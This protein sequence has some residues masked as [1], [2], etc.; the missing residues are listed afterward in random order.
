MYKHLLVGI[1]LLPLSNLKA[2]EVL[3]T[4]GGTY[5][6]STVEMSFT[7]GEMII[8]TENSSTVDLTQGFHQPELLVSGI[9]NPSK[10]LI[11]S[12]YP[13]PTADYINVSL[14]D[15][16][17]TYYN[18]RSIDGKLLIAGKMTASQTQIDLS[19][20]ERGVYTVEFLDA[21]KNLKLRTYQII[22]Q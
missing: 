17:G 2:Q 13:N 22:K 16:E 1:L 5:T 19:S 4:L 21:N 3:G 8:S 11:V 14:D 9:D 7:V 20:F 15:Y 6:N 12:I 10:P 18:V